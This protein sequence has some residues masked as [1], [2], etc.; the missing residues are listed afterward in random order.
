MRFRYRFASQYFLNMPSDEP[1]GRRLAVTTATRDRLPALSDVA[2]HAD[3]VMSHTAG[4]VALEKGALRKAFGEFSVFRQ[5]VYDA[6][7]AVSGRVYGREPSECECAMSALI[8]GGDRLESLDVHLASVAFLWL[9]SADQAV[10][11]HEFSFGVEAGTRRKF[12]AR[13]YAIASLRYL[14][15]ALLARHVGNIDNALEHALR[16]SQASQ[17]ATELA[18]DGEE[19][20][21]SEIGRRGARARHRNDPKQKAKAAVYALWLRWQAGEERF[22]NN[23][24]FALEAVSRYTELESTQTVERWQRD[25]RKGKDI[26]DTEAQ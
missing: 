2:W 8:W 10:V 24:K 19:E 1:F 6:A 5:R 21:L 12:L 20:I 13:H 9:D 18:F 22:R 11:N 26:P 23:A 17:Q 4:V 3:M 16:A 15:M 14:E 7:E 25:W